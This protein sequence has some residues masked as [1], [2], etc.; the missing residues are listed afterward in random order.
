M[1]RSLDDWQ[2]RVERHFQDLSVERAEFGL[3]VFAIEHGL[4]DEEIEE[5]AEGLRLQLKRGDRLSGHWLLWVIYSTEHGYQYRGDEYWPSFESQTPSWDGRHRKHLLRWFSKFLRTYNGVVPSGRWANHFSIISRP[6]THAIL[7]KYL[8]FQFAKEL[9]HQ[10]RS[11]GILMSLDPADV[12]R[13]FAGKAYHSSSRFQDFLQ[14]EELTGRIVLGLLG[15]WPEEGMEPIYRPR[16]SGLSRTWRRH[17]TR[18]SGLAR[19]EDMSRTGL[20]A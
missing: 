18:A 14:Q 7:P 19:P 16:W 2:T 17:A 9:F 20:L 3:D 1:V 6:I 13:R 15:E 10:R 12:G 8:Q 4:V 11:L 5:I